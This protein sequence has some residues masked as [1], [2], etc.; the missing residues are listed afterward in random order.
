MPMTSFDSPFNIHH[1]PYQIDVGVVH[2][3]TSDSNHYGVPWRRKLTLAET[4]KVFTAVV[5]NTM[6]VILIVISKV[7]FDKKLLVEVHDK[8]L[9]DVNASSV[10][11][12]GENMI[13]S[14]ACEIFSIHTRRNFE[15]FDI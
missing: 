4:L 9:V 3:S 6:H 2:L 12:C 15:F 8:F 1:T 11:T 14:L 5:D 7:I 13:L 10:Q